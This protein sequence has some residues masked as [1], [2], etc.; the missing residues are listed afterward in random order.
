MNC[1]TI[2]DLKKIFNEC[3]EKLISIRAQ[4][5]WTE[6]EAY[7]GWLVQ[8]YEYALNSSRILAMTGGHMPTHRSNFA[9]RFITH[10]A[11]ERG[12]E[13]LLENDVKHLGYDIKTLE[14]LPE[15]KAFH[16]SLYYWIA[17]GNS[18]GMFGWVLALEGFAVKNV[19]QM[20]EV[21]LKE[22]GAKCTTFLK[23]HAE[24]DEDHLEKAFQN[25]D[26]LTPE[27]TQLVA[28][29]MHQYCE[30]YGGMMIAVQSH[31]RSNRKAS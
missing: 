20:Y 11:E 30:L 15:A 28:K 4:F 16:Q 10:A 6:K 1:T 18:V 5:P 24:E 19:P 7:L 23:V 27:E 26:Q 2:N 13:K 17:F 14:S 8:T 25:I 21:C 9:N 3:Q 12:H 22:Y 29:T 31:L